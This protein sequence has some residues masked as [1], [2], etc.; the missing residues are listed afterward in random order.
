VAEDV[1]MSAQPEPPTVEQVI[2]EK[3]KAQELTDGSEMDV[4]PAID[5]HRKKERIRFSL[6]KLSI[7]NN[8]SRRQVLI[9]SATALGIFPAILL[10]QSCGTTDI[11]VS[12]SAAQIA[13]DALVTELT[14]SKTI[15]AALAPVILAYTTTATNALASVIAEVQSADSP[16]QK[17]T[18]ITTI[19]GTVVLSYQN[20]SPTTALLVQTAENAIVAILQIVQANSGAVTAATVNPKL[21]KVFTLTQEQAA[22]LIVAQS[23]NDTDKIRL[24]TFAAMLH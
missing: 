6:M 17:A 15:P 22:R 3:S 1:L 14:I 13:V 11:T 23:A 2:L 10:Q 9:R 19:I 4:A 8:V 20:L 12:I 24:K 18:A 21:A 7:N 5:A 16:A